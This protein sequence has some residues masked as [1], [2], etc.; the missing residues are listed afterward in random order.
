M[1][2]CTKPSCPHRLRTR[3]PAEFVDSM[4]VCSDCGTQLVAADSPEEIEGIVAQADKGP[5]R[6]TGEVATD[7]GEETS[8]LSRARKDR[9]LGT[10]CLVGG[11]L[12]AAAAFIGGGVRGDGS[13]TVAD[14]VNGLFKL[15]IAAYLVR[16]GMSLRRAPSRS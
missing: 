1:K 8:A 3:S 16:K 9:L 10:A 7:T 13:I 14:I 15:C 12:L 4:A 11:I 6:R 2:Y 5:T